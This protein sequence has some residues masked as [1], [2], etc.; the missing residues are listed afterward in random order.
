M[1]TMARADVHRPSAMDPA[2]YVWVGALGDYA[3]ADLYYCEMDYER[4]REHGAY[5]GEETDDRTLADDLPWDELTERRACCH[6]GNRQIRNWIFYLHTPTGRI[7]AVGQDC[8]AKLALSSRDDLARREE[9]Q[10]RR[11]ADELAKWRAADERNERAYAD[12][13]ATEDAAGGSGA[14][15]FVDSLLRYARK[16]G[17]L[18]DAQRDAVLHGIETRAQRETERAERAAE[19]NDPEPAAVV[20]GRIEVT[21]RLLTIKSQEGYYGSTL[22]MLVLDDRGFKVW[23]T[24]PDALLDPTFEAAKAA[25]FTDTRSALAAGTKIRVAFTAA[26]ERS[27]DDETFGF[28]KRPTKARVLDV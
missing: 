10:R 9:I 16:N 7:I 3:E 13:L 6:C 2:D 15:E 11:I 17:W 8:S 14:N 4:L 25:G 20:T 27:D 19:L 23:G 12:L 24:A 28:Y 18:T 22:K 26:V 21:G 1:A 5:A